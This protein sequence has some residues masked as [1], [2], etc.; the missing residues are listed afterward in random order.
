[1]T[2]D[3]GS[4]DFSD[5]SWLTLDEAAKAFEVSR[6]TLER[7]RGKGNLPGV[8]AGRF[9]RVRRVDVHR[10]LTFEN[11]TLALQS[12]LTAPPST[13]VGDW[14]G[15]WSRYFTLLPEH[16]S[17]VRA[18]L[19]AWAEHTATI[20]GTLQLGDLRVGHVLEAARSTALADSMPMLFAIMEQLPSNTPFLPILRELTPVF[21]PH[22]D[23][24]RRRS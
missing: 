12:L 2:S 10:A 15:D 17:E 16:S 7:L 20:H 6:R 18:P 21:N 4:K 1:M 8:R 24:D 5:E 19:K 11:P 13:P 23:R 22:L 3:S 9:L 14:M